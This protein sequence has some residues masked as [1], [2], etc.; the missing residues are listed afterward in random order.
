M[1]PDRGGQL[2]ASRT[3]CCSDRP[4]RRTPSTRT[5]PGSSGR[6]ADASATS[7]PGTVAL[8]GAGGVGTA[9][10]AALV[11]LGA[12]AIR[13]YDIVADRSHAL[14]RSLRRRNGAVEVTVAT[15]AEEAVDGVD[16]VVNGTPVGM[17]FQPGTPVE[18]AA[19]GDQR[20]IFDAIYSPVET[21]LMP[22]PPKRGCADQR[23]R[24]VPRPGHRRLRDVHRLPAGS[25][26]GGRT[27]APHRGRR[28]SAQVLIVHERNDGVGR[29]LIGS[30]RHIDDER[31]EGPDERL[32]D[33]QL[34]LE[35]LG[36]IAAVE[37]RA[38]RLLHRVGDEVARRARSA[39]SRRA[40]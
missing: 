38:M 27:R 31:D 9:T 7:S 12:T 15:S 39:R 16:G 26:R 1:H 18:L 2:P 36:R 14:A 5:S 33:R 8:L 23:L 17:Y 37:Q 28:T 30:R 29:L 20:W 10:A 32:A 22:G 13:I 35:Q 6:T 34:L 25:R 11:D 3:R 40:H 19:I 4:V 21:E 24:P